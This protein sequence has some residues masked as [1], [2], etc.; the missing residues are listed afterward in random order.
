MP[1]FTLRRAEQ[2]DAA[3][4]VACI[5]A[6]YAVYDGR[7]DDLPAVSDGIP[8]AIGRDRVWVACAGAEV[9]GGMLL[10]SRDDYLL[11]E[12]IAVRPAYAGQGV[13]RA[14]LEQAERDGLALGLTE[15][16]LSTHRDMPE[17]L[18]IYSRLG[19]RETSRSGNKV[20]M[21]KTLRGL[22]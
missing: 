4:L 22:P 14:L 16:R 2:G 1:D 8:E 10:V 19:W 20:H 3:G 6:A 15:I 9:I 13:G 5:D 17:N 11:L 18:T 12:N 21:C 7:V